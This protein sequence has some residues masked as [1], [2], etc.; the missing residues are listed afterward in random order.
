M[1]REDEGQMGSIIENYFRDIYTTSNPLGFG[2]ILNGIHLAV[3]KEDA[4]L[5]GRDFH[6]NEVRLALD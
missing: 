3:S 2:E 6:A 1:W 5:I 4:W